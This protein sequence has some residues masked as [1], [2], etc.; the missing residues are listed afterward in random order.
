LDFIAATFALSDVELGHL[1]RVSGRS[2]S[3]WRDNGFPKNRAAD[4]DRIRELAAYLSRKVIPDRL[5]AVIRRRPQH[6]DDA[7]R[8]R[9][10]LET[11]REEGVLPVYRALEQ[12]FAYL[13]Y[14]SGV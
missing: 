3:R 10:I 7:F 12:L 6:H 14:D 11:V 13:G 9:S 4:V 2:M 5:P 8:G 1:F